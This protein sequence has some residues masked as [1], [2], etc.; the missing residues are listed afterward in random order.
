M[1]RHTK[2]QTNTQYQ[3]VSIYLHAGTKP[4]PRE[5]LVTD[6][7]HINSHKEQALTRY[8]QPATQGSSLLSSYLRDTLCF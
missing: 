8:Q 6:L 7:R 2:K 5:S 3:H 1:D 4:F